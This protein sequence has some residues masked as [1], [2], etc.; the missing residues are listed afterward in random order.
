MQH[1]LGQSHEKSWPKYFCV[2]CDP[3]PYTYWH[4]YD[5]VEKVHAHWLSN[6]TEWPVAK[7]FRFYAMELLGCAH[8][9]HVG[10]F[11][12]LKTHHEKNHKNMPFVVSRRQQNR[13]QCALCLY[14]GPDLI[15]HFQQIH[16]ELLLSLQSTVFNPIC[17][18]SEFLAEML[19]NNTHRRFQCGHCGDVFETEHETKWHSFEKHGHLNDEQ[20]VQEAGVPNRILYMVC[21]IC[22]GAFPS[23][24]LYNHILTESQALTHGFKQVYANYLKVKVVFAN[25]LTVFKQ[26][27]ACTSYDDSKQLVDQ[28]HT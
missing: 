10:L 14:R 18:T 15:N 21:S 7:P 5:A 6:H 4:S 19:Q 2:Y 1:Q 17:F 20:V 23:A 16:T 26:N 22:G 28:F 9:G 25:G 11:N 24:D 27:L 13:E 3:S 8:C 12:Y